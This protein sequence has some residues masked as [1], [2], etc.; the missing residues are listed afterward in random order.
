MKTSKKLSVILA[1]CALATAF[2]QADTNSVTSLKTNAD[3]QIAAR[4]AKLT[5]L[6]GQV[7]AKKHVSDTDKA[8]IVATIQTSITNLQALQ[9][10]IDQDTDIK[11]LR[12]DISSIYGAYRIYALVIPQLSI[13]TNAENGLG[14]TTNLYAT[15]TARLQTRIASAQTAGK[16]VTALTAQ[17][18]DIQA[19]VADA[20]TQYNQAVSTVSNL[21]PDNG[22][23][24]LL[25]S[26][27]Q[28]IKT[29]RG[30]IK[31]AEADFR[32]AQTDINTVRA[33]LRAL[34]F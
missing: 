21:K 14:V 2:A 9:T 29:A 27:N 6:S 12:T 28:A 1:T 26:N 5:T 3:T 7:N 32:A 18:S 34:H 30:Y 25:A 13:I 4:I 24:T 17:I 22:D 20:Q 11:V 15:A 8:T 23:K 33:A 16:D 19:K 31:A 10:K